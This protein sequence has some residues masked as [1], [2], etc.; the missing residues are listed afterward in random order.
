MGLFSRNKKSNQNSGLPEKDIF[1]RTFEK[2]DYEKRKQVD[3]AL[4]NQSKSIEKKHDGFVSD[5]DELL[6]LCNQDIPVQRTERIV[7]S[8][9]IRKNKNFCD[10]NEILVGTSSVIGRRES[11]QDALAISETDIIHEFKNKWLA[12]LCDGMGGMNGGEQASALCVKKMLEAF[13]K[14]DKPIPEF[15]RNNIADID[16]AVASLKDENGNYL[17]AGSTLVSVVIDNDNLF[18]ASVGDSHIYIIRNDEMALVNTEHNYMMELLKRVKQGEITLE[19]A[20]NDKSRDALISYMGIGSISLMDVIE[21]P[22]K[23]RKG[24]YVVLCSDGLYRSVSDEEIFSIVKLN[25]LNMQRAADQL[26]ECALSKNNPYQDN[27]SVITI[28]YQ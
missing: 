3:I 6:S 19:E 5:F 18:W 15:Y 2:A 25:D 11:Q 14:N 24:D 13:E 20:N 9:S 7:P 21:K 10:D 26:T 22:F 28:K 12:V 4:Q 27:T 8:E 23:L 1:D 16:C 17:G